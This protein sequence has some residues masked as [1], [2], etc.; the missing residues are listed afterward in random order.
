MI[1]IIIIIIIYFLGLNNI[2]FKFP[3]DDKVLKN[4]LDALKNSRK[5]YDSM[6]SKLNS[7]SASKPK[8]VKSNGIIK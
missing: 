3:M 2:H 8:P 7:K 1:I 4:K 5:F 6:K